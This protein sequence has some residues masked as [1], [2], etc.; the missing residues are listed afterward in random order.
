[1]SILRRS[2]AGLALLAAAC[3]PST[4]GTCAADPEEVWIV[5][6]LAFG[7]AEGRVAP[8]F[9]L[10]G[11]VGMQC[12]ARDY[13]AP[14]GTPGID[15]ALAE[16]LPLVEAQV[17]GL[18][19]DGLVQ[20]SIA[21]GQIL[22]AF[23]LAGVD[24]RGRDGCVGIRM[25]RLSGSPLL[26]SDNLLL[27]YQTLYP[28][29]TAVVNELGETRIEG[30][31][32]EPTPTDIALPVSILDA[33]FT[34]DVRDAHVR[35]TYVG[36]DAIEG[37]VAGGIDVEQIIGIVGTLNIPDDLEAMAGLLVRSYADL[38]PQGRDCGQISAVLTFRAVPGFIGD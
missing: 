26:S 7:R 17:G 6:E 5:S 9:D 21:S 8:G 36:D 34:L 1:V 18:R 14:D 3:E 25:R 19:L 15:N 32:I 4:S 2:A 31:R 35:L 33:R 20:N 30:A 22:L 27:P 28:D 13:T 10:D 23:E 12:G 16:L 11:L 24:D 38:E 29:D 37:V